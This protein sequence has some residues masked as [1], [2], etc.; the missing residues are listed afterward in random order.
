MLKYVQLVQNTAYIDGAGYKCLADNLLGMGEN[1][2]WRLGSEMDVQHLLR[3]LKPVV[4]CLDVNARKTAGG[5]E[6]VSRLHYSVM[7]C[8]LCG[9]QFDREWNV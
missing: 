3:L 2:K 9:G 1:N 6:N 7:L 4:N 8:V 5:S